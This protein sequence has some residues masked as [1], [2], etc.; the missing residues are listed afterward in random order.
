LI[1]PELASKVA[2]SEA[3]GEGAYG[4]GRDDGFVL[5]RVLGGGPKSMSTQ[6][7]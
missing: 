4:E 1:Q 3:W 6:A 2:A 7:L 5:G